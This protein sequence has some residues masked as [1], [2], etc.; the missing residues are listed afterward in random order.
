M[1]FPQQVHNNNNLAI[2]P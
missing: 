1:T 2:S